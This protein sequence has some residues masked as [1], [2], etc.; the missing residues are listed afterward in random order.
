M[1]FAADPYLSS[2]R[3]SGTTVLSALRSQS[4]PGTYLV[5]DLLPFCRYPAES[6]ILDVL[7]AFARLAVS[8]IWQFSIAM[9]SNR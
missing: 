4:V 3:C 1:N 7:T 5:P 6:T 8:A 9:P 2:H